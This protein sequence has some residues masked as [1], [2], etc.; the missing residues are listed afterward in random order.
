MEYDDA[1]FEL[2]EWYKRGRPEQE[3]SFPTQPLINKRRGP[4][5]ENSDPQLAMEKSFGPEQ[6]KSDPQLALEKYRGSD[7]EDY[8]SQWGLEKYGASQAKRSKTVTFSIPSRGD[9]NSEGSEPEYRG[10]EQ[11]SATLENGADP[12]N[13]EDYIVPVKM[14]T[15]RM[16]PEL[17]E[18]YPEG[19]SSTSMY[20]YPAGNHDS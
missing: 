19:D 1:L 2:F 11:T 4:E 3:E 14:T 6:E 9:Q 8:L 7:Q 18:Q 5:Q 12:S 20:V 15:L 13:D 10:V 16:D 17:L